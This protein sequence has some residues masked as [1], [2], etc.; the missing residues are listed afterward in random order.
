VSPIILIA[1]A[2]L[3]AGIVIAVVI[4]VVLAMVLGRR[5]D[6]ADRREE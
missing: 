5:R 1:A 3:V 2:V 4:A 6:D